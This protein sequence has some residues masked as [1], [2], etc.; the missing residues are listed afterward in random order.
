MNI[1]EQ[2][3]TLQSLFWDV[4]FD[5]IDWQKHARFVIARVVSRGN[6]QNLET[7]KAIYGKK[8]IKQEVVCVRSLDRS[9]TTQ[10]EDE[11][12][13]WKR[14]IKSSSSSAGN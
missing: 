7:L 10:L 13:E 4:A 11:K 3:K 6:L 1:Q 12:V 9:L 8:K 5:S 2:T 14:S